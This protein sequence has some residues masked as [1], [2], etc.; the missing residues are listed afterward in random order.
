M[1]LSFELW[2]N[3]PYGELGVTGVPIN[4]WGDKPIEWQVDRVAEYGYAGV[5][6]FYDM[7]LEYPDK[8]YERMANELGDYVRDKGLVIPSVGAHHLTLTNRSW[9]RKGQMATMKRAIDF[10]AKIG[11]QTVAAYIAGYYWPQTYLLMSR[12]EARRIM[13]D[14]IREAAEYCGERGLTFSIEPHQETYIN[15][16]EP[17]IDVIEAVGLDNVRVTI[18]FGGMELGVKPHMSIEDGFK[19]F[20]PYLNHI[21]AKDITGVIGNWNMCWFG[22]GMVNF[23]RYADALRAINYTG[24]IAVEWEGWFKGGPGGVGD[25]DMP[26]LGDMDRAAVEIRDFLSPIFES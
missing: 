8:E 2:P 25:M 26:G 10:S 7:F 1:K 17:T 19:A 4:S 5:D 9:A 14:T 3:N 11:A 20:A 21:H 18:D 22:G 24:Y 16:P 6:F 12:K 15:L 23:R 13:I